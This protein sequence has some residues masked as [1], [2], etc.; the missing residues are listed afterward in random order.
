MVETKERGSLSLESTHSCLP[1]A[2]FSTRSPMSRETSQSQTDQ[3]SWPPYLET[4]RDMWRETPK[5]HVIQL[6]H[7]I[8]AEAE[9]QW[10]P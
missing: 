3:D 6:P 7:L 8:Q 1:A 9:T 5:D 10:G 2:S 4:Q